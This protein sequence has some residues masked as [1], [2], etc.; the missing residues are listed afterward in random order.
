VSRLARRVPVIARKL[1]A[2]ADAIYELEGL[3]LNEGHDLPRDADS[4]LIRMPRELRSISEYLQRSRWW[5]DDAE[6]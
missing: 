5:R 3:M 4:A 2:A 6:R 1:D